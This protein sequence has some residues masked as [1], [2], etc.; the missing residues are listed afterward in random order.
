MISSLFSDL[1]LQNVHTNRDDGNI[2]NDR[3]QLI[4]FSV[5]SKWDVLYKS[6]KNYLF[7][8][9]YSPSGNAD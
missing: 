3:M 1:I 9:M 2:A 4:K 6:H 5:S 8:E 7:L